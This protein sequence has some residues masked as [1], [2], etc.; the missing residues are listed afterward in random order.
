MTKFYVLYEYSVLLPID[1]RDKAHASDKAWSQLM[2][3]AVYDSEGWCERIISDDDLKL[4]LPQ[5]ITS[6]AI[7]QFRE[8]RGDTIV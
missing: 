2:D 5:V 6:T 3:E 1:A 8:L 4:M 7:D